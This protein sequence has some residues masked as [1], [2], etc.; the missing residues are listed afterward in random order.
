MTLTLKSVYWKLILLLPERLWIFCASLR[1]SILPRHPR[2]SYVSW[3]WTPISHCFSSLRFSFRFTFWVV[4]IH[5]N[6]IWD[7]QVFSYNTVYNTS[8]FCSSSPMS[9]PTKKV[10]ASASKVI[11][12]RKRGREDPTPEAGQYHRK[13]FC[14]LFFYLFFF[15]AHVFWH[16]SVKSVCPL[17]EL[18]YRY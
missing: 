11:R 16:K 2:Y 17:G 14:I 3:L 12:K 15:L 5:F 7:C 6:T 13:H 1:V 18:A 9:T 10:T 8:F 4:C